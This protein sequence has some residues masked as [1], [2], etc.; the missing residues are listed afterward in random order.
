MLRICTI[1]NI[2]L[3]QFDLYRPFF[4]LQCY[5]WDYTSEITAK[6]VLTTLSNNSSDVITFSVNST[7]PVKCSCFASVNI[8]VLEVLIEYD[9]KNAN[10]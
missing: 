1:D 8:S 3:F 2:H 10:Y 9:F 7:S 4:Y 5:F 6:K